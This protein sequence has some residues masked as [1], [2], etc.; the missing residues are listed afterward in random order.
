MAQNHD[1]QVRVLAGH[2]VQKQ[3]GA[4]RVAGT[5]D[6]EQV[7]DPDAQP[8]QRILGAGDG[9]DDA[10]VLAAGQGVLDAFGVDSGLDCEE[11]FDGAAWH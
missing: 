3:Q 1:V 7:R 2:G 9:A 4:I 10:E 6:E 5:G 8:A 11:G